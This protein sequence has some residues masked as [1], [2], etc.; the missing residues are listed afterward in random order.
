MIIG[1]GTRV[2]KEGIPEVNFK[3]IVHEMDS[4]RHTPKKPGN[5]VDNHKTYTHLDAA[6]V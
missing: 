4:D 5:D 6:N 1:M 2:V 3:E